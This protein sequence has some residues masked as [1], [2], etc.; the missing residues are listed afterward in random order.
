MNELNDF[1]AYLQA[2]DR[3]ASTVTGYL[4]DVEQ[5]TGWFDQ[6]N[7]ESLTPERV[8]PT[9]ISEY[10]QYMLTVKRYKASTINRKLASISVFMQ[11]AQKSGLIGHDPTENIRRVAQTQNTPHYLDKKDQY[12][13]K[14]AIEKELQLAQLR[15][16]KRWRT[17]RRDASMVTLLLNTGLRISEALQ[18]QLDDIQMSERK[19]KV[20]VIGKGR[21]QRT[22]PLNLDARNALLAWL[23][24]RPDENNNDYV[25]IV[26]EGVPDGALSERSIQRMVRRI[27]EEAGLEKLTPHTL[28]HTFAKNLV[29]RGVGLE[30]VAALLGHSSLNTTRIYV[31]PSEKDLENAVEML[32]N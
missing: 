7:G 14:R 8:T 24:V 26:V 28:R 4:S 31:T 3:S 15:Y 22:I 17:R 29:N 12:A 10:R 5:F 13:L 21:K 30:K 6:T 11:W 18:L 32:S 25:W 2:M 9:D 1:T 27:G 20:S 23:R 16:P 19:G